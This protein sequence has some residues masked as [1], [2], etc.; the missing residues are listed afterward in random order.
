LYPRRYAAPFTPG[1]GGGN[2]QTEKATEAAAAAA[3]GTRDTGGSEGR[4]YIRARATH[5]K[6]LRQAGRRAE[7]GGEQE[8]R[9]RKHEESGG[10]GALHGWR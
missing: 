8:G 5:L 1:R 6:L 10:A 9:R 3:A 7:D 2:P 4:G